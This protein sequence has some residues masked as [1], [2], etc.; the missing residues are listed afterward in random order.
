MVNQNQTSEMET[1]L[2]IGSLKFNILSI[3]YFWSVIISRVENARMSA[4]KRKGNAIMSS[5]Y[6]SQEM[7]NFHGFYAKTLDFLVVVHFFYCGL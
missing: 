5:R 4:K 1:I 6:D 7:L 2:Q 3:I